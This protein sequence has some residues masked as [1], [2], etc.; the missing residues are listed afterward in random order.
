MG[1]CVVDEQAGQRVVSQRM[2]E[3]ACRAIGHLVAVQEMSHNNYQHIKST[4]YI[5]SL[6]GHL[7]SHMQF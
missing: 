2:G 6:F 4:R 7:E 1:K 5:C 3:C